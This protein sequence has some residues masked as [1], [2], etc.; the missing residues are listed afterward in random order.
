MTCNQTGV[1]NS[2]YLFECGTEQDQIYALTHEYFNKGEIVNINTRIV[3]M[4]VDIPDSVLYKRIDITNIFFEAVKVNFEVT[5]IQRYHHPLEDINSLEAIK[6]LED[7]YKEEEYSL[8]QGYSI[9]DYRVW[10]KVYK[11]RNF[12]NIFVFPDLL[13]GVVGLA[14]SIPA[15]SCALQK[16]FFLNVDV[17]TLEHEL[18]HC[19]GLHHTHVPDETDGLNNFTGDKVRDTHRSTYNLFEYVD[20]NCNV[21]GFIDIP[22]REMEVLTRNIMSYT[23]K[24]CRCEFT[25][26]QIMRMLNTLEVNT[27]LRSTILTS[28][29]KEKQKWD[30]LETIF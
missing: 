28:V 15:T 16:S 26:V 19:F 18:G 13:R 25:D 8:R 12:I 10:N 2:D 5:N 11:K 7:I 6:T 21:K 4:G 29:R 24:N 30:V 14:E 23:R 17:Y 20:E 22:E 1:K 27:E 3:L 9:R